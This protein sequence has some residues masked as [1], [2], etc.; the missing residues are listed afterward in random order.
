MV[1]HHRIKFVIDCIQLLCVIFYA[2]RN[3]IIDGVIIDQQFESTR[4]KLNFI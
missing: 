2:A 4:V 1:L 3:Q